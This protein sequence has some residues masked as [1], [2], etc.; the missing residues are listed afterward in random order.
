VSGGLGPQH[1]AELLREFDASGWGRMT[2]VSEGLSLTVSHSSPADGAGVVAPSP[3]PVAR[4]PAIAAPEA[5][6]T[7]AAPSPEPGTATPSARPAAPPPESGLEEIRSPVLGVFYAA[8]KP[9][10]RPF[11]QVGDTVSP[12]DSVAIVEVMKLMNII[13]AGVAG[14]VV[15]VCAANGEMVDFDQV[16]IRVRPAAAEVAA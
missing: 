14:E 7:A 2:V 8:P 1:L 10:A 4:R 3:T 16:L 6:R 9:G 11:V 5:G 12:D 13:H 15:E